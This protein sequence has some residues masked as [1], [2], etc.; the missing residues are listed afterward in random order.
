VTSERTKDSVLQIALLIVIIALVVNS[1][2]GCAAYQAIDYVQ[3]PPREF[4]GPATAQVEFIPAEAVLFRCINRG[5][6]NACTTDNRITITNAC[7]YPDQPYARLMCHE[8]AHVNGW[9][10]QHSTPPPPLPPEIAAK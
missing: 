6:A 8:M 10:A 5:I 4:Q 1:L 2:T 9:D 3:T 7:A